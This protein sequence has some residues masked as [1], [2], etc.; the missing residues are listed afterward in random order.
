M[1][2]NFIIKKKESDASSNVHD[3]YFQPL[4]WS[5]E[6]TNEQKMFDH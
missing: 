5:L 1:T 3:E 6:I 2:L 4:I